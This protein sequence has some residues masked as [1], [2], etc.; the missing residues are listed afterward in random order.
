M[1][2][3]NPR[4]VAELPLWQSGLLLTGGAVIGAM[5]VE[6]TARKLIP[7]EVRVEH[8]AVVS[9]VFTVVG[10]T[11]A[12]LLA[13]VAM[14]ALEGY[15]KAEAVTGHEASLVEDVFELMSALNGPGPEGMR[16]DI[17]AYTRHVV[18]D[19]W[20]AQARGQSVPEQ[21][22]ALQRLTQSALRVR[23]DDT[24]LYA[25][26]LEKVT[27]LGAARRERLA[28]A[29]ASI[30]AIVWFVLI[31]GGGISVLFASLLGAPKLSMQLVTSSLLA[32]SGALVLL[33]VVA[34]SNPFEGDLAI[35]DQPFQRVLMEMAN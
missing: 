19:E 12:V 27:A 35:S 8:N 23:P 32:L 28:A 10:T 18:A 33:V 14:L 22:S 29:R 3:M 2:M 9:T 7:H 6:W 16:Q 5:I 30:P 21:V 13:F 11:Y 17:V 34:L 1:L 26:L 25:I 24:A 4:A 31:A 20:P 15:N